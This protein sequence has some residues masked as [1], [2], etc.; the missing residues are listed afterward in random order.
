MILSLSYS[1]KKTLNFYHLWSNV[2][3][4]ISELITKQHKHNL[5]SLLEDD[6]KECTRNYCNLNFGLIG[7]AVKHGGL[8]VAAC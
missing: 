8:F 4:Y 5:Q 1:F 2:F 7:V 3:L 6:S